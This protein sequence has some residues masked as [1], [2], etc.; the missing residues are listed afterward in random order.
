MSFLSALLIFKIAGSILLICV[1]FLTF[2]QQKLERLTR[3]QAETPLLFRLYGLA[4]ISLL[5]GY[6]FALY[7]SLNNEFPMHGVIMGLVSNGGG[8]ILLIANGGW[9][10]SRVPTIFVTIVAVGLITSLLDYYF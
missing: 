1:P 9:N 3:I 4:V 2:S 5:V 8:S 10:S 7:S 6:S